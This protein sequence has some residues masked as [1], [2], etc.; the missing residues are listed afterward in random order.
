MGKAFVIIAVSRISCELV[1]PK[2]SYCGG[3][4]VFC[5]RMKQDLDVSRGTGTKRNLLSFG[6][7]RDK[8]AYIRGLS[9]LDRGMCS[10]GV[11]SQVQPCEE[12]EAIINVKIS[13]S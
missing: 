12:L 11:F 2:C 3:W 9:G 5:S 7:D 8:E 6:P 4:M 10:T 13:T 1:T